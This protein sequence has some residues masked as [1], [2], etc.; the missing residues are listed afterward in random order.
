[1]AETRLG[2]MLDA[3]TD[4]H[5]LAMSTVDGL[6][7]GRMAYVLL[8]RNLSDDMEITA[9]GDGPHDRLIQVPVSTDTL[10][11]IRTAAKARD[12]TPSGWVRARLRFLLSV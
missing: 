1:M 12:L 4:R 10:G 7:V 11:L 3:K 9:D 8:R 5:L 2:V 6:G